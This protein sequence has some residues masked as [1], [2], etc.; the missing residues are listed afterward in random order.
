MDDSR[1]DLT[2]VRN[3]T[4]SCAIVL[5]EGCPELIGNVAAE[6]A[7]YMFLMSR[8]RPEL[9]YASA[10]PEERAPI[11]VGHSSDAAGHGL[12]EKLDPCQSDA[13]LIAVRE[14]GSLWKSNALHCLPDLG[15]LQSGTRQY[16]DCASACGRSE[17]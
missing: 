14:E 13:Y 16:R 10:L 7:E 11:M 6:L 12:V 3:H 2:L 5:E 15:G 17:P 8:V 9:D 4:L 1:K